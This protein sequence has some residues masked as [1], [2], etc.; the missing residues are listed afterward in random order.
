MEAGKASGGL[1]YL[2]FGC[3]TSAAHGFHKSLGVRRYSEKLLKCLLA[4]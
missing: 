2:L 3:K 1:A 4:E